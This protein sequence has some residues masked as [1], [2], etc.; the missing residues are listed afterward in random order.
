MSAEVLATYIH[1]ILQEIRED[2]IHQFSEPV[3]ITAAFQPVTIE[4]KRTV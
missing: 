2:L 4:H 1:I 3:A